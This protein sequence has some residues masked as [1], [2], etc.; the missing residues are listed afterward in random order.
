MINL[1]QATDSPSLNSANVVVELRNG[2]QVY[3]IADEEEDLTE[4]VVI[5][6]E[7]TTFED[8]LKQKSS[9]RSFIASISG[10]PLIA[11]DSI[12]GILRTLNKLS[13]KNGEILT[14]NEQTI[15][16]FGQ[17]STIPVLS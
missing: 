3:R 15:I 9:T 11:I 5:K 2:S 7:K 13:L 17:I 8:I 10:G 16:L 1:F 4:K 14:L 12:M 6:A